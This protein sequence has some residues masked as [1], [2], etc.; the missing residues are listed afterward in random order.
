M[1][2]YLETNDF[3]TKYVTKWADFI[4]FWINCRGRWW[5]GLMRFKIKLMSVKHG[6]YRLV[7]KDKKCNISNNGK[8]SIKETDI[9]KYITDEENLS[10]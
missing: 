5:N 10:N 4:Y 9:E 3:I 2:F 8:I 7:K 1:L 6:K